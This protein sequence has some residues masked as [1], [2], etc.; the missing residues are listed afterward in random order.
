MAEHQ[1]IELDLDAYPHDEYIIGPLFDAIDNASDQDR[2]TWLMQDGKRIAAIV[3]VA[4]AERYQDMS[5]LLQPG[6]R[7]EQRRLDREPVKVTIGEELARNL[8]YEGPWP[9]SGGGWQVVAGPDDHGEAEFIR[10]QLAAPA[11]RVACSECGA[12]FTGTEVPLHTRPVLIK[13]EW[14]RAGC[15]GE[16]GSPQ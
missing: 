14:C 11:E 8:G 4:D 6:I 2:I 1:V 13:G 12:Q 5:D 7:A 10:E 9:P 16:P 3:P 15:P